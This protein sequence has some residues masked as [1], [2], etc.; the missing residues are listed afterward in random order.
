MSNPLQYT[1]RDY[2]SVLAD[3]NSDPTLAD[4]PEWF[5]RLIAGAV[6]L[7][8]IWE[9]ADANES[10]L[11]TCLTRQAAQDILEPLGYNLTP[12]LSS[13]G[14]VLFDFSPTTTFP[15]TF[16][17]SNQVAIYP[18]ST[19]ASSRRFEGR[20]DAALTASSETRASTDWAFSTGLITIAQSYTTGELVRLSTTGT[21]PSGL[22]AS[23]NYYVILISSTTI[24][25]A[26]SRANAYS[27]I[28]TSFADAG[29]GNHTLTRL[30]R[31]ITV[32]QQ[33]TMTE[34]VIGKSDG[35]TEWQSFNVAQVGI[36]SATVQIIINGFSWAVVDWLGDYG[37][38][39]QVCV[40]FYQTDGTLTVEF[41]DGVNYGAI[42]GP[43][44]INLIAAYGGG[45]VSNITTIGVINQYGGTDSN[46][47]GCTNPGQI[48][49]GSDEQSVAQARAIAPYVINSQ[50]RFVTTEDGEA[51]ALAYG[52]LATVKINANAYG[53]LSAQVVGIANGGGNPSS[54]LRTAIATYLANRSILESIF[55]S[56]DL[57]TITAQNVTA[58][59]HL[60]TGYVWSGVQGAVKPYVDLAFSL[61]FSETGSQI[62]TAY[63]AGGVSS[64]TTLINTLFGTSFSSLDY[65][66]ID[67]LMALWTSGAFSPRTFGETIQL[68]MIDAF[69]QAGVAGVGYITISSPTFPIILAADKI[70]T[71]GTIST[72]QV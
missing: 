9:N 37:P 71:I 69:V 31:A 6:D 11:R 24:K 56:F 39:D 13:S 19:S 57:A 16:P 3:I 50:K 46:V 49:Q 33:T 1:S 32:Y 43:Y 8:S 5:K 25:L 60:L 36:Q 42:P 30:S 27:G 48:T 15:Y 10:F 62:L 53:V 59:I 26:T 51:L 7:T 66:A 28:A 47:T 70:T 54:T 23:T 38:L 20:S 17:Q 63:Q 41:G 12:Q 14:T 34:Q 18:G 72:S 55:V 64:A 22:A 40:L 61:A 58:N 35:M 29:S 2:N 68:S 44:D 65:T 4:K 45:S 52:G 21:L 67:K